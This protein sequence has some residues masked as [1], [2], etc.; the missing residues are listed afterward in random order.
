MRQV[1]VS[2]N[3]NRNDDAKGMAYAAI[4]PFWP[5]LLCQQQLVYSGGM[6]TMTY[7][8]SFQLCWGFSST[9]VIVSFFVAVL[10]VAVYML[11]R[12]LC[13]LLTIVRWEPHPPPLA[14]GGASSPPPPAGE[15]DDNDET[16]GEVYGKQRR[17]DK[18][19]SFP[20]VEA[21]VNGHGDF[22][23]NGDFAWT[24]HDCNRIDPSTG[25][26]DFFDCRSVDSEM[27]MMGPLSPFC[28]GEPQN[29]SRIANEEEIAQYRGGCCVYADGSPAVVQP[30]DSVGTI[31]EN[32]LKFYNQ[33]RVATQ[34]AWVATQAWRLE[35]KVWRIH[36]LPNPWFSRIKESYPHFIHGHSKSGYP[37]IYEQPGR[38]N[39][40]ELFRSGCDIADMVHHYIFF[41]EFISNRICTRK[42]LRS[43]IG[44]PDAPAHNSSL[45]GTYVVMDVSGAGLSHLNGDVLKYLKRAGDINSQ[46]Y[47]LSMKRAFLVNSPF[48]LAGA[49]SG[50]KSI[51]P[52]SVPVDILSPTN[53]PSAL[54]HYIDEDQIPIE[55]GGTSPYKLGEHPY[56][57]E[58]K[59]LVDEAA[60]SA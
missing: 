57:L 6:S 8:D 48:W 12:W 19:L 3:F 4:H 9:V 59:I 16:T 22:R 17:S 34:K 52:A 33:D 46:H 26:E 50:L 47:P 54:R 2:W 27:M 38:M 41:V 32:Y 56:E 44:G 37:I 24:P 25:G 53:Y 58:L 15:E 60:S 29:A 39:L 40:K 1:V 7:N 10:V 5:A 35:Q 55:Y 21:D 31:P 36:T 28:N 20:L 18:A 23:D 42:D 43:L 30:G 11:G 14:V 13:I 51:L 45:W 49:W